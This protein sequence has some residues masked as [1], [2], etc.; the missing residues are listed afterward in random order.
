MSE[1]I[2]VKRYKS[3]DGTVRHIKDGKL[4]NADGPSLIHP[5]GRE[6]YWVDGK[7]TTKEGQELYR[8]MLFL[9]GIN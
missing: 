7:K 6:E 8:G 3:P 1:K 5:D 9:K 4:H 2:Q